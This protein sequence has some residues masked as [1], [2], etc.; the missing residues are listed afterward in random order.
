MKWL[1]CLVARLSKR[2]PASCNC[3]HCS[4]HNRLLDEVKAEIAKVQDWAV[5]SALVRPLTVTDMLGYYYRADRNTALAEQLADLN[6]L[7]RGG[8]PIGSYEVMAMR[9]ERN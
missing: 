6:L 9:H 8:F 2:E 4:E 5:R 7:Q 1:R 3:W